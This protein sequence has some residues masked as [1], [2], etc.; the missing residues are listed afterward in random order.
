VTAEIAQYAMKRAQESSAAILT[1]SL[2][3]LMASSSTAANLIVAIVGTSPQMSNVIVQ[4]D[5]LKSD[6]P[7]L[8]LGHRAPSS[9]STPSVPTPQP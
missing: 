4:P 5:Q 8:N 7:P 6:T 3:D 9:D 1:F 2:G